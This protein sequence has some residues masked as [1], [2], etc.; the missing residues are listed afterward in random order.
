MQRKGHPVVRPRSCGRGRQT[1]RMVVETRRSTQN[2]RNRCVPVCAVP[3]ILGLFRPNFRPK[4]GSKPKIPGRILKHYRGSF[5][6]HFQAVWPV[7]LLGAFLKSGRPRGPGKANPQKCGGCAPPT[8]LKA[9]LDNT[10][11]SRPGP[12]CLPQKGFR[13]DYE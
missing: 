12:V 2:R 10:P 7:F 4:S 1:F 11:F 9:V 6:G 8:F 3:D 5:I 13:F